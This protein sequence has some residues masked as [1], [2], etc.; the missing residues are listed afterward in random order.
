MTENDLTPNLRFKGEQGK[1]YPEWETQSFSSLA[2]KVSDNYAPGRTEDFPCIELE[3]LT[4]ETGRLIKT[5][6]ANQKKSTKIKFISGDVLFGKLRPYLK[7]FYLANFSGVCTTEIWVLRPAIIKSEFLY[8]IMQGNQFFRAANSQF[9]S[10]MPRSDWKVVSQLKIRL[11]SSKNEQQKIANFLSSVDTR[12]EYLEKKKSLLEQY[13]KGLMQKLFSQKI[14]FKDDQG[15]EFP[16]WERKAFVELFKVKPTRQFQI[17]NSDIQ[18]QGEFKVVDQGKKAIAGY[19]NAADKLLLVSTGGVIVYGD[20]TTIVKFIDFDFIVG[21]DG[22][23]VLISI[24]GHNLKFLYFC[25]DFHNIQAEGYKRHF[26]I[27]KKLILPIPDPKEQKKIARIL[28]L[29]E[30]KIELTSDQIQKTRQ[31]KKGLLQKMFV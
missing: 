4:S 12:I 16:E 23:K 15:E 30:S 31:Y 9:G 24:V 2:Q 27:L 21:A 17:K 3:N 22:T 7:K 10:K 19:S 5:T 26:S 14:R 20:H 6:Q 8:F 18:S 28:S 25:L 11:P 1:E 13:K 29:A